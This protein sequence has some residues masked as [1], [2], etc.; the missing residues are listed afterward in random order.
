LGGNQGEI[1]GTVIR[2]SST[3]V[4]KQQHALG[5]KPQR[6]NN[7]SSWRTAGRWSSLVSFLIKYSG[8]YGKSSIALAHT[9]M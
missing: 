3:F 4:F 1:S 2:F 7:S 6:V 9:Q 8:N 5:S